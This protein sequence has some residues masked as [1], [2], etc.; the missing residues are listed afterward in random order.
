VQNEAQRTPAYQHSLHTFTSFT[1]MLY[2][3]YRVL[4]ASIPASS[5][6]AANPLSRLTS[7]TQINI[8]GR[9]RAQKR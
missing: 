3:H 8:R 5:L 4:C 2:I 9:T 7:Q 6:A 1:Y